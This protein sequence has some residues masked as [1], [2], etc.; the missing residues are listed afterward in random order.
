M[1]ELVVLLQFG[2]VLD[3]VAVSYVLSDVKVCFFDRVRLDSGCH[4]QSLRAEAGGNAGLRLSSAWF[5]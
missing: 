1:A 4:G 3:V 5:R 2:L